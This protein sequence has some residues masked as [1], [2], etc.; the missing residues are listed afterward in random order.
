MA[1]GRN[2]ASRSSSL[3]IDGRFRSLLGLAW[4][5]SIESRHAAA[6]FL[7]ISCATGT[8]AKS[9]S[10]INLGAIVK[11]APKCFDFQMNCITRAVTQFRKVEALKNIENF[12]QRDSAG[13]WRRSADDVVSPIRAANRLTFFDFV[14]SEIL[15]SYQASTFVNGRCQFS[16]HGAVIKLVGIPGET[17]QR[18][19]QVLAA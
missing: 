17:L 1:A 11:C 16:R 7:S 19:E 18:T 10:P 8:L 9:G 4:L 3:K 15:G 6:Y 14:G 13:R 5:G 12:N 2:C